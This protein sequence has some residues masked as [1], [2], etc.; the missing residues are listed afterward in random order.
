MKDNEKVSRSGSSQ[1]SKHR[2]AKALLMGVKAQVE[3][4]KR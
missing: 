1:G 2:R 3:K 4:C